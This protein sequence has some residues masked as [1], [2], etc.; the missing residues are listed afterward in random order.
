MALLKH[1]E[2]FNFNVQFESTNYIALCERYINYISDY[3][4]QIK[5]EF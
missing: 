3:V 1:R 4:M 5:H 2:M